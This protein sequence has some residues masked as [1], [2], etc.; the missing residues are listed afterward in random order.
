MEKLRNKMLKIY[1]KDLAYQNSL[2]LIHNTS[3]PA[4]DIDCPG[5]CFKIADPLTDS[6]DTYLNCIQPTC[7]GCQPKL[8]L[9]FLRQKAKDAQ[10]SS[11]LGVS[12]A[13]EKFR[14][15][16]NKASLANCNP[17]CAKSQCLSNF[18]KDLPFEVN[19]AC[20][21]DKCDCNF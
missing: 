15:P 13:P 2:K 4:C 17:A 20:T 11:L 7:Q 18:K 1:S 10:M 19:L 5:S 6:L 14:L 21:R 8:S 3:S 16:D 12:E 9:K